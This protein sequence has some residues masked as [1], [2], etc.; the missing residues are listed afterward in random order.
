MKITIEGREFKLSANGRFLKK[1]CDLFNE[2][3]T[4]VMYNAIQQRDPYAI[5][6]LM[7]CA[8]DEEMSFEDWLNSFES[9][10]FIIPHMDK[11]IE[12]LV[13]DTTPKV[14]AEGQDN[15]PKKAKEN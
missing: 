13:A 6:K 11:V 8:I 9:P 1:Y 12:Y 14:A 2:N 3:L 4:M 15:D 10:L 7:Y 5:A